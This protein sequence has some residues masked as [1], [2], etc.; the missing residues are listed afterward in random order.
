MPADLTVKLE[1]LAALG[2]DLAPLPG[3]DRHLVIAR[4]GIVALVERNEEG[5]G[6]AG[7]PGIL[8]PK[9]FA[10]LVWRGEEAFFVAKGLE[11]PAD[12]VQIREVRGFSADLAQ[13]MK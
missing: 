7:S 10:A 2:F 3:F 12:P 4:R 6:Q 8:T 13:A 1:R 9:G 11:Q 5:L